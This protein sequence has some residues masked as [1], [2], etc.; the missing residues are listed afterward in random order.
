MTDLYVIAGE[1]SADKLGAPIVRALLEMAPHLQIA[2]IAGPHLRDLKVAGSFR[3]EDL[4]VMGFIDVAM[5]L[6]RLIK[7][8]CRTRDEI[9]RL[10]PKAVLFIDYPGFN[11][12]L[13][14][15]LR[16]RGYKGKL[17]HAVCPSVWAWGKRRIPLMAQT[18]DLLLALFPF[19]KE[20][21]AGTSLPIAFIGHPL[22]SKI[23][24]HPPFPSFTDSYGL[25]PQKPILA[26]FPGSRKAAIERNLPLQLKAAKELQSKIPDLSIAVSVSH[27][28]RKEQIRSLAPAHPLIEPAHTYDLMRSAHL[29]LATSGTITL[30]LALFETPTVVNY[31]LG[32]LDCFLAKKVFRI[33]LPHYCIV[34]ILA[35]REVFPELI[36][37]KLDPDSL[38]KKA[39]GLLQN[40]EQCIRGCREVRGLLGESRAE[41]L[42]AEKILHCLNFF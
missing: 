37:P 2:G 6:P 33:D 28:E 9:L 8:F 20:S 29:A 32:S 19:E 1:P 26:L 16:K 11:L 34:N 23:K 35:K 38:V 4:Q 31:A 41:S 3:M 30:E 22:V 42:A 24:A 21:F 39:E 13:A 27:P 12:R 17:I 5:A 36:G 25:N 14:R 40:R 7:I 15:S 18:L 10:N